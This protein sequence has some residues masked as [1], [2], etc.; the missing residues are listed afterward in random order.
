[1]KSGVETAKSLFL[2]F[3]E[4]WDLI[5]SFRYT[6]LKLKN[7]ALVESLT[8]RADIQKK[9]DEGILTP[10][11]GKEY[12][13]LVKTRTDNLIGMKVLPKKIA[14]D[15]PIIDHKKMLAE[16]EEMKMLSSGDPMTED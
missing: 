16:F 10:D 15:I 4:I 11:E 6:R 9:V 5:T 8:I 3:K 13:H 14:I 1:V 12:T 7:Q 2:I